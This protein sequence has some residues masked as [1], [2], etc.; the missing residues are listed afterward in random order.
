M[1]FEFEPLLGET[2]HMLVEG[3]IVRM[4]WN[5]EKW[6]RYDDVYPLI[7]FAMTGEPVNWG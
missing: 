2:R 1:T 6:L 4:V 3:L 7:H 5:G